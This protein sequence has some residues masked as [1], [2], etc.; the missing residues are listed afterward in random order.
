MG[1]TKCIH[2]HWI[3]PLAMAL[4]LVGYGSPKPGPNVDTGS[5]RKLAQRVEAIL[6]TK[7]LYQ[8]ARQIDP[9]Q[10]LVADTNRL[11]APPNVL[12]IHFGILNS[13]KTK[14]FDRTRPAI[15]ICILY[16][17]E[18]GK[19]KL[20]E[21]NI[22]FSKGNR[23]LPP[24]HESV[25]IYGSLAGS[26]YNLAL[27]CLQ[28]NIASPIGDLCELLQDDANLRDRA[29]HGHFW[30]VLPEEVLKEEQV[31]ISLWR[32]MDQNENQATDQTRKMKQIRN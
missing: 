18:E 31:D 16:T 1:S 7:C 11:G 25:A 12:H 3:G 4:S 28:S 14:G 9:C 19:K 5:F 21:H 23:L 13:F 30:W 8:E 2:Q 20:L 17:S 32:N 6:T 10:V 26:H 22:R 15:G 27:R 24:I 29:S